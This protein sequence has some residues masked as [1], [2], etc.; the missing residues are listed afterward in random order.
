M[1]TLYRKGIPYAFDRASLR[2]GARR[3]DAA[4]RCPCRIFVAALVWQDRQICDRRHRRGRRHLFRV[5]CHRYCGHDK[6]RRRAAHFPCA[7]ILKGGITVQEKPKILA[8]VG[9]T[10][11]GK[12]ALA[13]ALAKALDGEVICC[14]SMQIYRDM[15]IG[16][17][18]PTEEEKCGVIHHHFD[19]K[20]PDEPFSAMEYVTL[21][22]QTVADILSRGKL[23]VFCGGTGLY[24]DAFLR[25]GM[26]QTPGADEALRAQLAAFA[27][28]HGAEAL[29]A[30][31]A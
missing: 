20:D 26:P 13:V 8:V 23:P 22:E 6:G 11:S 2:G 19:I 25:G 28:A 24:L 1:P 30:Q 10:A 29:H 4:D 14:D 12:T 16:T 31:L 3:A 5:L 15:S 21:A 9:P 7:K 27:E 18:K 17:A